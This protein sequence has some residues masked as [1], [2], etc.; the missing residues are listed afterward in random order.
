[1][2]TPTTFTRRTAIVGIAALAALAT[3]CSSS[4][5]SS[6]TTAGAAGGTTTT[7]ATSGT[8][9]NLSAT[10]NASGAT[11]PKTFYEE[12][13]AAFTD[14]NKGVTINYAGGGSG[15]GR[16]DLADEI[17]DFAGTDGTIKDADLP[18]FKGGAVL[19]FPTV[20]AP[21]T[22]S[23]HLSGVDTL[24]L[25]GPTIAGIFER[26]ITKWNDAAIATDN[27]G[28]TLPA[29]DI[30]VVHRSDSSGTTKNF[31][32]FLDAAA[33]KDNGGVWTLGADN[34]VEWPADTQAGEGNAGVAQA[35]AATDGAIGYVDLSDAKDANLS[36]AL[37]KNKAG[38][39]VAP[40]LDGAAAAAAGTTVK[41]N[42]TFSTI[43]ADGDASYPIT[44][45]TW[46][47]AYQHQKDAA[48][49]AA[50]KAFLQFI[51]TDGQ[52]IAPTVN[53]AALPSDLAAKA[54]AQIATIS[55]G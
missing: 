17:V 10:L 14:A 39:F 22:V 48:K 38:K 29:T 15:K 20:V 28:V 13:I 35:I 9:A 45:Q 54:I 37:V 7:A 16:Q 19:Y 21:I 30:V 50:L 26:K 24:Q 1:M 4:S 2:F 27:P 49:A 3:A 12:A 33:G 32:K 31:T 43:W 47:I 25:S 52:K 5:T 41:D 53:Y 46:I 40:T 18:G 36:L 51:L 42:L 55:V 11:F 34:T 44:A 23:Y 6:S 8:T